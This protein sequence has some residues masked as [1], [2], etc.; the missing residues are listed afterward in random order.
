MVI[1]GFINKL[2]KWKEYLFEFLLIFLAVW[3]SFVV[4]NWRDKITENKT[5]KILAQSL[6]EDLKKDKLELE[7]AIIFNNK[8]LQSS[9]NLISL[10]HTPR[11]TWDELLFYKHITVV[12]TTF[13]FAPTDGTYQQ[14]K[15]TGTLSLFNQKLVN[16]MNLNENQIK[17]TVYR[18][19]IEEKAI[20]ELFPY[21]SNYINFEVNAE[22]RFK[23]P[24]LSTMYIKISD[25]DTIEVFI[26]KVVTVKTM[27]Y[28]ALQAYKIQL[29]VT[30]KLISE[31]K[32]NY[33]L[34]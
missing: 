21:A 23:K 33:K 26:N 28:R 32:Q 14:M 31:L 1:V 34:N 19:S 30:N 16:D 13:P 5:S 25:K 27:C 15:S 18:Q 12:F 2:K 8:K 9:D 29:E 6:F 10:M 7:N 22:I 4:D 17:K 20:W 24:I 3:L 11:K